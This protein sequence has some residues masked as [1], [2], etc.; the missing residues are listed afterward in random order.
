MDPLHEDLLDSVGDSTRGFKLWLRGIFSPLGV[1]R[2]IGA[3]FR[4]RDKADRVYGIAWKST[5]KGIFA[6]L[7]E[8][9]VAATLS[10]RDVDTSAGIQDRKVPLAVVSSGKRVR[11]D[12]GW[13][14]RQEELTRV[15]RKL[16]GWD[17]VPGVPHHVWRNAKGRDAMEKRL[18]ELVR[19]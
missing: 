9:L 1:D 14:R 5:G 7:Q 15:T 2:L 8:N 16:R 17:V 6:R 11:E 4:G 3:I 18:K 12:E 10:R 19:G 13:E